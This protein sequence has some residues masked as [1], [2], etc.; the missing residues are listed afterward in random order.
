MI[1]GDKLQN[2][3]AQG[4]A[5]VIDSMAN[6]LQGYFN[7]LRNNV[8]KIMYDLQFR[9]KDNFEKDFIDKFKKYPMS[10]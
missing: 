4:Q 2:N 3:L 5:G 10:L 7:K 9:D 6:S 1:Q 8:L